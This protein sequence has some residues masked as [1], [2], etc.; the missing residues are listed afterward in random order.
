M[1]ATIHRLQSNYASQER[2][3][4]GIGAKIESKAFKNSCDEYIFVEALD[5]KGISSQQQDRA[6]TSDSDANEVSDLVAETLEL[7]KSVYQTDIT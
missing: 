4:K 2:G 3:V 1:T 7:L 5:N 6:D